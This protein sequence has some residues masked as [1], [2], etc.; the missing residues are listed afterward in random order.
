[1]SLTAKQ[2][3]YLKGLAHKRKPVVMLGSAGLT[4]AVLAEIELALARHELLKIRLPA[5]DR[6]ERHALVEDMC[7]KTGAEAV[8][9]IG[10]VAVLYRRAHKPRIE[11]P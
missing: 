4:P 5:V 1:M 2:R 10:R 8:Q 11:L 3:Q 6:D 9:E 7:G